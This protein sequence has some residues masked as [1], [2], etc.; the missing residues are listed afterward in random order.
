MATITVIGAGAMGSAIGRRL[1]ESGATVLTYLEGRSAATLERAKAAGMRPVSLAEALEADLVLSIV[2]PAEATAVARLVAA[3][4]ARLKRPLVFI[5][6][7]AISP[8][9]MKEA[10]GAFAGTQVEVIDGSIIG[11]PPRHGYNPKLYVSA[12]TEDRSGI[13]SDHG[14]TVRRIAGEIGAASALK[15]CYAGINK[16]F[17]GLGTAMLLAAIRNGADESLKREIAESVPDVDKR[18]TSAI[19]DMYPKAYR[20]V[21]EMG[22]IADFLGPDDPAAQIFR[23]MAALFEKMAADQDGDAI[24]AGQLDA[25]LATK[26]D[27]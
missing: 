25:L 11:G 24:L 19:P 7:N 2:P 3:E 21:A 10:A 23:G 6:C 5:D 4:A 22:E 15:M 14:L 20:W 27:T 17:V 26:Q 12:D 8:A 16:G 13:L 9:T 18:L 1:A